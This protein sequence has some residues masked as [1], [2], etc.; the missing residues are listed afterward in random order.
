MEWMRL[1]RQQNVL[2]ESLR[3][4]ELLSIAIFRLLESSRETEIG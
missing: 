2:P 4:Q 3:Q 1:A